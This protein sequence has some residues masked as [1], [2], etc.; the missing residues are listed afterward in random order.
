[1]SEKGYS[2]DK[3]WS[4][5][6][7]IQQV[8]GLL[9][10]PRTPGGWYVEWNAVFYYVEYLVIF[11][12][13]LLAEKMLQDLTVVIIDLYSSKPVLTFC[14]GKLRLRWNY[15]P[16]ISQPVSSRARHRIQVSWFLAW[17]SFYFIMLNN[18][19]SP[20]YFSVLLGN[21]LYAEVPSRRI[22]FFIIILIR[23]HKTWNSHLNPN[24]HS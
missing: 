7:I 1:M 13:A 4:T 17:C 2:A 16:Q 24:F 14:S 9:C 20:P 11:L 19:F 6:C 18:T 23:C 8:F 21:S 10:L 3:L 5:G 12:G 22:E 15:L